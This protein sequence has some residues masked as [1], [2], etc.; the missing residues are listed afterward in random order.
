MFPDYNREFL[1]YG[2][3]IFYAKNYSKNNYLLKRLD[4]YFR[5]PKKYYQIRKI[6]KE[7]GPYTAIHCCDEYESGVYLKAALKEGIPI[8]IAHCHRIPIYSHRPIKRWLNKQYLKLIKKSAT[9]LLGCSQECCRAFYID[10]SKSRVVNNPFD[11][12]SFVYSDY[13]VD[14][15]KLNLIQVASYNENKNQIFSVNILNELRKLY[16]NVHLSFVGFDTEEGYKGQIFREVHQLGLEKNVSF[17]PENVDIPK[18]ISESTYFLLPSRHEGFGNVLI[19]AQA[20]GRKCFVSDSVPK[21]TNCGGCV[22]LPLG[23]GAGKWAE[24]IYTSF[25]SDEDKANHY[26]CSEFD[27]EKIMKIYRNIYDGRYDAS[28]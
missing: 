15:K 3:E 1:N 21:S 14:G 28:F 25:I 6:I 17:Y 11:N 23:V 18:L 12:R 4:Y 5:A 24:S 13:K 10:D 27:E 16:E 9:D 20:V 22:Y 7:S 19:E 26:D 8:R 2:G